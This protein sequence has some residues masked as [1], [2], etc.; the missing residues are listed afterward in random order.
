MLIRQSDVFFVHAYGNVSK[1][2]IYS[3]LDFVIITTYNKNHIKNIGIRLLLNDYHKKAS[4]EGSV[5]KNC[6]DPF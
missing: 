1:E 6:Q 5:R 4:K 3:C 2:V